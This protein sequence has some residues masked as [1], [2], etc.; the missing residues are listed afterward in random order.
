MTWSSYWA[1][2]GLEAIGGFFEI[3]EKGDFFIQ[4]TPIDFGHF[5]LLTLF[6]TIGYMTEV[7]CVYY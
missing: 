6:S 7:H 3:I 2:I 5:R 4:K 1:N